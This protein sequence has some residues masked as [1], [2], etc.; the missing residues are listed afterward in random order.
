[1]RQQSLFEET[2]YRDMSGLNQDDIQSG[3]FKEVA[4]NLKKFYSDLKILCGKEPGFQIYL[5][6][7]VEKNN[8]ENCIQ[9][10]ESYF[11]EQYDYMAC[12]RVQ[13]IEINGK[14]SEAR[15]N[16][17][18][19]VVISYYYELFKFIDWFIEKIERNERNEK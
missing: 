14:K 8:S 2:I 11:G 3:N 4:A 13:F 1:M 10:E 12:L 16:F 15:P 9:F 5:I 7:V 19:F 17:A 6:A 18:H